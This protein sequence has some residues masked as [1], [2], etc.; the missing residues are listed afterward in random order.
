MGNVQFLFFRI[1]TLELK[2]N[3]FCDEGW[4][5]GYNSIKSWDFPDI[6]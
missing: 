4:A 5:L 3:S 6:L 2:K 1:F